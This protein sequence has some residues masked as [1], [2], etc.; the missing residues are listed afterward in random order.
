[1]SNESPEPIVPISNLR[2][3]FLLH[4]FGTFSVLKSFMFVNFHKK[5]SSPILDTEKYISQTCSFKPNLRCNYISQIYSAPNRIQFCTEA[6]EKSGNFNRK[7][8]SEID[9]CVSRF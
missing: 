1:M 3:G 6:V 5:N 2:P 7:F 9:F 8:G 4:F